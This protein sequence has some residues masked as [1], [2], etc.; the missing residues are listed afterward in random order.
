MP[1]RG[2][3]RGKKVLVKTDTVKIVKRGSR[4]VITV[5][6]GSG[7]YIQLDR[8]ELFDLTDSLNDVCDELEDND[9]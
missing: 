5:N 3:N 4:Y 6:D 7:R 8:N 2:G 9:G 1:N